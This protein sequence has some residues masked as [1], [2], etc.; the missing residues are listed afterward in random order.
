[1][2]RAAYTAAWLR[3]ARAIESALLSRL[4]WIA[5]GALLIGVMR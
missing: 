4:P 1:M 3:R 5:A 2:T